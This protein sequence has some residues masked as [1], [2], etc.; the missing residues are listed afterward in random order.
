MPLWTSKEAAD[1][2]GGRATREW[3]AAS[4]FIDS[5]KVEEGGLFIA[6]KG[7]RFDG[8]AYVQDAIEKG[9]AAAVVAADSIV[10]ADEMLPLLIVEDTFEAL[11]ALATT[12]RN[13]SAA[14]IV[15]VTG[16]VGKTGTKE[17]LALALSRQGRCHST[18]GNLNNHFG[19]PLTMANM[20]KDTDFGVY[21]L[22]MNHAG[23]IDAL[24]RL[25]RPHVAVI[26]TVQAVHLEFFDSVLGIADAKSEIFNGLDRDG[27]AVLN[28][29]HPLFH[30][31]RARAL[32]AGVTNIIGFGA[33]GDADVRLVNCVLHDKG[34]SVTAS[35]K[36]TVVEYRLGAPG[37]HWIMN[38][39]AVLAAID[40]LGADA[41][42]AAEAMKDL[43]PGSGRG[44][45]IKVGLETGEFTLID[46]SYNASPV[47]VRAAIEV[48]AHSRPDKGG[49]RIAVLGDMLEL[50]ASSRA[51]HAALARD[52]E[53]H[54]IDLVF[55]A[56][57][58]ME[59]LHDALPDNMKG[60]HGE[61][62]TAL[63]PLVSQAVRSG[64]LVMVKGSLG[65]RMAVI[66]KALCNL[67]GGAS[68]DRG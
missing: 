33:H 22:G 61:D 30:H 2:T 26:T 56:G 50:G 11:R 46:E 68:A 35:I 16:S 29:D 47:S 48:L 14:K 25:L 9:A 66:V 28:R 43:A 67:S 21:E 32:E 59:A 41:V 53:G 60:G 45:T 64:D 44:A 42:V 49:R 58:H 18:K 5:R 36:G 37:R 12:A 40:A 3:E 34:S 4:V 10:A 13:R 54:A 15:A 52:L 57:P 17:A 62:S 1:A 7:E 51:L 6:I 27:T 20:P 31:I 38:S 65:S 23:E 39:L 63:E 8:H 24:S 19:L 55:T